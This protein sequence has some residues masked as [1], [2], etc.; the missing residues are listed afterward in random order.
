MTDVFYANSGN[1]IN[2]AVI[3]SR[4][5]PVDNYPSVFMN[6]PFII[7]RYFATHVFH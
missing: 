1:T 6:I 7:Y 3:R 4:A 5:L 2:Y